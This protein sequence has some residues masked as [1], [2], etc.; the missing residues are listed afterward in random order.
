MMCFLK[1]RPQFG[2]RP[3]KTKGQ[4]A[5]ENTIGIVALFLFFMGITQIFL[6]MNHSIIERQK[7]FQRSRTG[8]GSVSAID[9]YTQGS[10]P[11]KRLYVFPEER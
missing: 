9:F 3:I 5:I 11:N 6:W 4:V 7:A 10:H 8:L 1:I 2:E